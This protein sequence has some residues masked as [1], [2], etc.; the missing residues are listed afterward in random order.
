MKNTVTVKGGIASLEGAVFEDQEQIKNFLFENYTFPEVGVGMVRY[1]DKNWGYN[2]GDY[3]VSLPPFE[4]MEQWRRLPDI[5]GWEDLPGVC[6]KQSFNEYRTII[7]LTG[8]KEERFRCDDLGFGIVSVKCHGGVCKCP[9][10]TEREIK[11]WFKPAETKEETLFKC[12]PLPNGVLFINGEEWIRKPEHT[13][14]INSP[15]LPHAFKALSP[16]ESHGMRPLVTPFTTVGGNYSTAEPFIGENLNV[17]GCKN[18][19][20]KCVYPDC[21]CKPPS[22]ESQE[23]LWEA[24]REG[25]RTKTELSGKIVF[26]HVCEMAAKEHFKI[27]LSRKT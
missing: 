27:Y 24:F 25:Y 1:P 19:P 3:Q 20:G 10:A 4:R 23:K 26:D 13:V 17:F 18:H 8:E 9:I 22:E 16:A 6:I 21:K 14:E 11:E 2:D 5:P 12:Q 15:Q 7:R